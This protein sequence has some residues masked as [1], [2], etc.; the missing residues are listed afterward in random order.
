MQIFIKHTPLV[1]ILLFSVIF[2]KVSII[3]LGYVGCTTAACLS[4]NGI[5]VV[6]VDIHQKK[7]DLIN[8]GSGTFKEDLIHELIR[9]AVNNKHLRATIDEKE[10]ILHSDV[11][12]ICVGTPS[13]PDGNVDLGAL[14]N[15][16]VSVG[17]VL[18][19]K[20]GFH[21]VV[22]RSTVP[23]G[24]TEKVLIPVLENTSKKKAF[25]DFDVCVNPEFMREGTSVHD[26]SYP[27]RTVIGAKTNKSVELL[28]KIYRNVKAPFVVTD[29]K[30]A[31]FIKYAD[32]SFHALKV[33]YAN[34]I[35]SLCKT[36]NVNTKQ[37]FDV[38]LMDKKL[39]I[40]EAYLRPGPPFGGS[41]LPKEV[42]AL[43][44]LANNK[45]KYAL[46][47]SILPSNEQRKKEILDMVVAQ[48]KLNVGVL[49]VSFKSGTDD[50]R[51]SP[52]LEI[53]K[54]LQK[55]GHTL[56]LYDQNLKQGE[57]LP[58][59]EAYLTKQFPG[60]FDHFCSSLQEV[61]EKSELVLITNSDPVYLDIVPYLTEKH[62]VIDYH[63]LLDGKTP[64]GITVV[65]LW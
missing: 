9:T 32:N 20:N 37:V 54:N 51:E 55:S 63:A 52:T 34:E 46:L 3:G 6:G 41:C 14:E 18:R 28:K 45:E 35:A 17:S 11:T 26:F 40:S 5:D 22:I 38:F 65:N 49:G 13:K 12:F 24:T 7:V 44:R 25:E 8:S 10:A 57:I 43:Q 61:A 56:H 62:V 64:P 15:T 36:L 42:R 2:M 29:I 23:P 33:A 58:L 60:L 59:N 16:C 47:N 31:E 27:S 1:V 48:K 50:T 21:T 30:T 39:N 4:Y 53:I 19:L